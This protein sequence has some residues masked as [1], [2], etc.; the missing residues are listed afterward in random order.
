MVMLIGAF[1]LSL[2]S[3]LD[4]MDW[5]ASFPAVNQNVDCRDNWKIKLRMEALEGAYK[6]LPKLHLLAMVIWRKLK[7]GKY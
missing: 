4:L 2:I 5:N 3:S 7:N 1:P 6:S